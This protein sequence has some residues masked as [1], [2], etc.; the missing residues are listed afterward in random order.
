L[1]FNTT[2]PP[3]GKTEDR[4]VQIAFVFFCKKAVP[5]IYFAKE[6]R[7]TADRIDDER[8]CGWK[9]KLYFEAFSDFI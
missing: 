3:H 7:K 4:W 2:H 5:S 6:Q 8:E 1:Y 9:W